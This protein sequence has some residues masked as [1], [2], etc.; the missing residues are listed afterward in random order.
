MSARI[1]L[2]P[3]AYEGLKRM[4]GKAGVIGGEARG[5]PC[6]EFTWYY[7]YVSDKVPA[8]S[9]LFE[10]RIRMPMIKLAR[11]PE[12]AM[13]GLQRDVD[14]RIEE[15]IGIDSA[16]YEKHSKGYRQI[17]KTPAKV[18]KILVMNKKTKWE[19]GWKNLFTERELVKRI[20]MRLR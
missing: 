4:R 1:P 2:P 8:G 19:S 14:E 15:L 7:S 18:S 12:I 9:R 5:V 13:A 6:Y 3:A 20:V 16:L 17:E 11:A 10:I